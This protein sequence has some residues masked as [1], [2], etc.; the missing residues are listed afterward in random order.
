[1][2]GTTTMPPPIPTSPAS[3]QAPAPESKPRQM[4]LAVVMV[5]PGWW[6]QFG[7]GNGA[8]AL[9][10]VQSVSQRERIFDRGNGRDCGQRERRGEGQQDIGSADA[11]VRSAPP[12]PR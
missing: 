10:L 7:R 4:R 3:R 2:T 8:R 5:A 1:M 9:E 11:P 6:R 12:K